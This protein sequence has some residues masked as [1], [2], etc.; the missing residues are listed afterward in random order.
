LLEASQETSLETAGSEDPMDWKEYFTETNGEGYLATADAQGRVNIAPYLRP[1]V[2][3]DGTLAFGVSD[4]R[5]HDNLEENPHA[6]YAFNEG[7][8]RGVRLYLKREGETDSGVLLDRMRDRAE[9]EILPG[10]GKH[11]QQVV[12]FRLEHHD[13]LTNV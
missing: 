8:Y 2:L 6:T 11:I 13:E 3:E 5:T 9:A 12:T 4:S 7:G 1:E 10:S